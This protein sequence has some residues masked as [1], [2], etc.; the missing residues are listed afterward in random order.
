[1]RWVDERGIPEVARKTGIVPQVFYRLRQPDGGSM[2]ISLDTLIRL[3]EVYGDELDLNYLAVGS[4][5]LKKA[6]LVRPEEK[7]LIRH[8]TATVSLLSEQLY[9]GDTP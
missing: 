4:A 6:P 5:A 3:K 9:D 1:M 7:Q 2:S 8:L